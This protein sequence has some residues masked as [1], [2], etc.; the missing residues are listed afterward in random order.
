MVCMLETTDGQGSSSTSCYKSPSE[1]F[2]STTARASLRC[3]AQHC[4]L[5]YLDSAM[6]SITRSIRQQHF[7]QGHCWLP[8]SFK[9]PNATATYPR[10]QQN[11][12]LPPDQ[13][14]RLP[15]SSPFT[16]FATI[17]LARQAGHAHVVPSGRGPRI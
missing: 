15:P 6:L 7:Q 14:Q 8:F 11:A 4:P 16:S 17:W 13:R 1:I 10:L 2:R 3:Y 12:D 5:S 9:L